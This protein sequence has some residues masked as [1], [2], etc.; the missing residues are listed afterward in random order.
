MTLY[1]DTFHAVC[2]TI[3]SVVV[4]V[5]TIKILQLKNG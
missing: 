4:S 5:F 3:E 2:A 1:L